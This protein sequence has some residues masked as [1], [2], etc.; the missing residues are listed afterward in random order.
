MESVDYQKAFH[1]SKEVFLVF[2]ILY[3]LIEIEFIKALI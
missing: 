1:W 3:E 2:N